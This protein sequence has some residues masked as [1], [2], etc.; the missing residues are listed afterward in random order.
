MTGPSL[1]RL[2]STISV[3]RR[4]SQVGA[5]SL[6]DR[7]TIEERVGAALSSGDLTGANLDV[8]TALGVVSIREPLAD[9][10]FRLKYANE[11]SSYPDAMTAVRTLARF[12][13]KKAGWKLSERHTNAMAK[14][15]LDYW[16]DD[17]CPA[18]EGR[19]WLKPEGAPI[20]SNHPCPACL[21]R[22][23]GRVGKRPFPWMLNRPKVRMHDR[24]SKTRRR[25]LLR[26]RALFDLMTDRHKALLCAIEDVERVIGG[27]VI[28]ALGR[29]VRGI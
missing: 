20:L 2:S 26:R 19:G 23:D 12:L 13:N 15:V 25:Q 17:L 24:D 16:L 21:G 14:A 18:C 7:K 8:L 4:C 28:A 1:A 6:E 22:V 11:A 5:L 10:V 27:K 3:S 29:E 9:A